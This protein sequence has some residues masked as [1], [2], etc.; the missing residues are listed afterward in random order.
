MNCFIFGWG[1]FSKNGNCSSY[2]E[3]CIPW[4][5]NSWSLG[6]SNR[7]YPLINH[8][9]SCNANFIFALL[10]QTQSSTTCSKIRMQDLHN[11]FPSLNSE[12][13][14][15]LSIGSITERKKTWITS[16]N[17]NLWFH[18]YQEQVEFISEFAT[19]QVWKCMNNKTIKRTRLLSLYEKI[20]LKLRW[21]YNRDI[22]Y[23][24]FAT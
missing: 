9:I 15:P 18:L 3:I 19:S 10:E 22:T 13:K 24:I 16:S 5:I 11:P 4:R 21:V 23:N 6:A 1:I 2:V 17:Q 12:R 8:S 20:C 14:I 7:L